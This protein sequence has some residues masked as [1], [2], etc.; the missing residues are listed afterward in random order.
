M[1]GLFKNKN[2]NTPSTYIDLISKPSN[3]LMQERH[4]SERNYSLAKITAEAMKKGK[5]IVSLDSNFH[6]DVKL[7]EEE[8]EKYK[9][10]TI[11]NPS[12]FEIS[13]LKDENNKKKFIVL[14][15]CENDY[16]ASLEYAFSAAKN[17]L[18]TEG[19]VVLLINGFD[20]FYETDT[21]DNLMLFY[22]EFFKDVLQGNSTVIMASHSFP[23][24]SAVNDKLYPSLDR[25]LL[26]PCF[27]E[28]DV[29]SNH[30]RKIV[31]DTIKRFGGD[32]AE[33]FS[34]KIENIPTNMAINL[35]PEEGRLLDFKEGTYRRFLI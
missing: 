29:I 15:R 16:L 9:Y 25:Y 19:D 18:E 22:D 23:L 30:G 26:L 33:N 28:L 1:F 31:I 2:L 20:L 3:I 6:F 4:L 35:R 13:R 27:F 14:K 5:T 21:E 11:I 24:G 10:N 8:T 34:Q 7:V 32:N 17:V 12:Y